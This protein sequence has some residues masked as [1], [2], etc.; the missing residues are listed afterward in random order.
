MRLFFTFAVCFTLLGLLVGTADLSAQE[1]EGARFFRGSLET[2]KV[3]AKRDKTPY[4]VAFHTTWCEPCKKMEAEVYPDA[5]LGRFLKT[6]Y[7]AMKV[8]AESIMYKD[9]AAQQFVSSF[10]TLIIF[11]PEGETLSRLGGYQDIESLM[12]ELKKHLPKGMNL[13]FSDFR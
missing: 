9:F 7:L 2:L 10:P 1:K 6:H 4:V 5:E 12:T 8:N 13:K 11:S 3:K